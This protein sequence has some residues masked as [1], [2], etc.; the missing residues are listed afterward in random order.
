MDSLA[1]VHV[2]PPNSPVTA[3]RGGA[4]ERI[5][6]S[7]ANRQA[8]R[9]HDVTIFSANE[10][11]DSQTPLGTNIKNV[12]VRLPRPW[13][14]FEYLFKVR[15][16]LRNVPVQ[17]VHANSTPLAG[18]IL[19]RTAP[20]KFL[21]L[22]FFKFKGSTSSVGRCFYRYCLDR[23]DS[24]SSITQFSA[25]E[26]A[27]YYQ[28]EHR[29]EVIH[30]GVDLIEFKEQPSMKTPELPEVLHRDR[31]ALYVG[32]INEQKGA[33][34]LKPLAES[35]LQD[36]ITLV[37]CG[38]LGQ[39]HHSGPSDEEA[40][41]KPPVHY[42]GAVPQDVLPAIMS[43][44]DVLVLPTVADEMFGMVLI[45][46]GACGTPAVASDLGGIPEVVGDAGVLAP[47]GSVEGFASA[48]RKLIDD[49]DRLS[50]LSRKARINAERFD[51][52]RIVDQ[53]I[54]CYQREIE[55]KEYAQ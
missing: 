21:T 17:V 24:V 32:R 28:L 12:V 5:V 11:K 31:L 16:R 47:V 14:D 2:L 55:A 52:D 1:I 45:E 34:L 13:C 51:W 49:P 41:V 44:A 38:P 27:D 39:F 6:L 36:R 30:C 29:P 9:G 15:R 26:T 33:R 7:I 35:L 42:L 37:A 25:S 3:S 23:F 20:L 10:G 53:V 4:V 8:A 19:G 40:W 54:A 22:N 43:A 18:L 46:A 50:E 48:I